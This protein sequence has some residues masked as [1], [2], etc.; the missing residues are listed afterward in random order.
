MKVS[1][2]L[3][4]KD[5]LEE[6]YYNLEFM[7]H[8]E[9]FMTK[10]R[11]SPNIKILNDFTPVI[12]YKYEGDYFGLLQY[13]NVEKK[14]H[15]IVLRFNGY[16]SSADFKGEDTYVLLPDFNEIERIKTIFQTK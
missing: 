6:V 3:E 8:V 1:S 9:S 4:S 2:L 5:S 13:L 10:L 11:N 12:S 14:Y 7:N 15:Y 16:E